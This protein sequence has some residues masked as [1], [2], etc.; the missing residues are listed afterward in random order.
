MKKYICSLWAG[1]VLSLVLA[2][3]ITNSV[4][5]GLAWETPRG[6]FD[7]VDEQGKVSY[8]EKIADVDLG[9]D[10]KIPLIMGF[11]SARNSSSPYLGAGWT[12]AL[13]DSSIVQ[14]DDKRFM[15]VQPDGWTSR[16]GRKK[17]EDTILS[18]QKGWMASINGNQVTVWATCG[19]K[20]VFTDGKITSIETPQNQ[21]LSYVY[22]GGIVKEIDADG[23]PILKVSIDPTTG[24]VNGLSVNN[25]QIGLVEGQ[26]P[27][28][29]NINGQ[30]VVGEVKQSLQKLTF[31]DGS[32]ETFKFAVNSK[33]LPTLDISGI[34]SR[35]FSW[36]PATQLILKDGEWSY[37]VLPSLEQF[38][39]AQIT[40]QNNEGQSEYW[41]ADG[42]NGREITRDINGITTTK[43][44]FTSGF[45]RG[46]TRKIEETK[47]N[48]TTLIY[49]ATYDEL[50]HIIREQKG[51]CTIV[52]YKP[53]RP[54]KIYKL[55]KLYWSG[56]Y[57]ASDKLVKFSYQ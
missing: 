38:S 48:S 34:N 56:E 25:K 37:K 28:V 40:R 41:F 17:A 15:M 49:S 9:K 44:V 52:Y 22:E 32:S 53:N 50:G 46:R 3:S 20:M 24:I 51:D 12:L 10:I 13:L 14:I 11:E 45:L 26:K 36:D 8:W 57:D 33:L 18:G 47:N 39:N 5:C 7:G 2:S 27:S 30:N 4:A 43:E 1:G 16:L 42:H 6:H 19:W 35:S 21:V 55:G 29:E 23:V 54:L 31:A